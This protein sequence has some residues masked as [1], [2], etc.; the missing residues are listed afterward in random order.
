MPYVAYELLDGEG[1]GGEVAFDGGFGVT[2]LNGGVLVEDTC[3]IYPQD[4]GRTD[5]FFCSLVVLLVVF[6]AFRRAV[7]VY[8]V[9]VQ[10]G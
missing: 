9:F 2:F 4:G 10:V 8:V 3:E 7:A 5:V 6:Q 1:L